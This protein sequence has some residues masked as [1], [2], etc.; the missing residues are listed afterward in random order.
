MTA[1]YKIAVAAAATL[2]LVVI[3]SLLLE[4]DPQPTGIDSPVVIADGRTAPEPPPSA[5][6]LKPVAPPAATCLLYTSPSPRDRG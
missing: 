4:K 5:F 3:A 1:P 6:D 2:L